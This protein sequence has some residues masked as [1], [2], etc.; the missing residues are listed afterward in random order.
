VCA[1]MRSDTGAAALINVKFTL[2]LI[3][4]FDEETVLRIEEKIKKYG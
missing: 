3:N 1:A 4:W 2:R